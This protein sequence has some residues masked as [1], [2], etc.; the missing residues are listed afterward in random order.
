MYFFLATWDSLDK[1]KHGNIIKRLGDYSTRFGQTH[2]PV[3]DRDLFSFTITHK[4]MKTL[5]HKVKMVIHEMIG[6]ESWLETKV[7]KKDVK[8]AKAK[9]QETLAPGR[10]SGGSREENIGKLSDNIC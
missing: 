10:V 8:G 7:W 3:V 1:D 4:W 6:L 9:V 5:H 2:E